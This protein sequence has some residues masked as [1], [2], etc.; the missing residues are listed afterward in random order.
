[1]QP[2]TRPHQIQPAT[3]P[4]AP[5]SPD[6]LASALHSHPTESPQLQALRAAQ[7]VLGWQKLWQW[8]PTHAGRQLMD[9]LVA[10]L[11]AGSQTTADPRDPST[12]GPQLNAAPPASGT[13]SRAPQGAAS[14]AAGAAASSSACQQD[15]AQVALR[16]LLVWLQDKG[17][18]Q[19]LG[20]TTHA[21]TKLFALVRAASITASDESPHGTS[22]VEHA[23]LL[24]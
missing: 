14:A 16:C 19:Q 23:A 1:M 9:G 20:A 10:W 5:S 24:H 8:L 12:S 6:A 4:L 15:V 3:H 21:C 17:A 2:E 18:L 22:A 11:G 7:A 13:R